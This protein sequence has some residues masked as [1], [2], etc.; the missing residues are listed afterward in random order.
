MDKEKFICKKCSFT[1]ERLEKL[2]SHTPK[3][4]VI[5]NVSNAT[6]KKQ[7]ST[8]QNGL[9]TKETFNEFID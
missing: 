3:I 2:N 1:T 8:S 6:E 9:Y 7:K 4:H 5:H